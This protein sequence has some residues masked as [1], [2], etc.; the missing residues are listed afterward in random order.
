MAEPGAQLIKI[1]ITLGPP[2]KILFDYNTDRLKV[3]K[4]I[5]HT[6]YSFL[7]VRKFITVSKTSKCLVVKRRKKDKQSMADKLNLVQNQESATGDPFKPQKICQY[8]QSL[9][10]RVADHSNFSEFGQRR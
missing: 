6:D 3:Y 10:L 1:V 9:V 5:K 7:A 4:Y 8:C 2:T